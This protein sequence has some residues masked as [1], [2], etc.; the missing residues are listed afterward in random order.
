MVGYTSRQFECN[1]YCVNTYSNTPISQMHINMH[2]SLIFWRSC[3]SGLKRMSMG[4]WDHVD[5]RHALHTTW[6]EYVN[7]ESE[8]FWRNLA[9]KGK[10]IEIAWVV[11]IYKY[12]SRRLRVQYVRSS[13]TI[14]RIWTLLLGLKSR[15]YYTIRLVLILGD[16]VHFSKIS[17]N[18]NNIVNDFKSFL[19]LLEFKSLF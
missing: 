13:D 8:C 16:C 9:F 3:L 6:T 19:F 4:H 2:L 17:M 12:S 11:L 7:Q 1:L 18:F 14:I 5:C 10:K 15:F